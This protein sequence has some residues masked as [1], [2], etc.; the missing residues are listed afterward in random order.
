[1]ASEVRSG[2]RQQ[3]HSSSE[4]PSEPSADTGS[5]DERE[6]S[7]EEPGAYSQ[8]SKPDVGTPRIGQNIESTDD[9]DRD[10]SRNG[11][12]VFNPR[13]RQRKRQQGSATSTPDQTRID[14]ESANRTQRGGGSKGQNDGIPGR[15][16][17]TNNGALQRIQQNRP[18]SSNNSAGRG[19]TRNGIN[20]DGTPKK[21]RKGSNDA[22]Y[23]E[24]A[25]GHSGVFSERHGNGSNLSSALAQAYAQQNAGGARTHS[26]ASAVS[27]SSVHDDPASGINSS[28]NSMS[29]KKPA[30]PWATGSVASQMLRDREPRVSPA[31]AQKE[32][33]RF[34]DSG[35][36]DSGS[37]SL[38]SAG[39]RNR[40]VDAD[41]DV[42]EYLL[43][44]DQYN[45]GSLS[46]LRAHFENIRGNA[47]V[48]EAEINS[49]SQPIPKPSASSY[50]RAMR[51]N[52]S[53]P[54]GGLSIQES[55][56]IDNLTLSHGAANQSFAG[57][58]FMATSIPL[59]DHFKDIARGDAGSTGT[60]PHA[61]S[62]TR[63]PMIGSSGFLLN[64]H[65]FSAVDSNPLA[66]EAHD[67]DISGSSSLRP[68][69][70]G[71]LQSQHLDMSPAVYP[72][73]G[74]QSIPLANDLFG[75]SLR[76]SSLANEPRS[77]LSSF[78]GM[79][80]ELV[81]NSAQAAFLG[82]PNSA[83]GITPG[84][85]RLRSNSN[86]KSPSIGGLSSG[87]DINGYNGRLATVAG[88]TRVPAR[89]TSALLSGESRLAGYSLNGVGS[90]P[91][92][93]ALE[94]NS[95]IW[96]SHTGAGSARDI[97][98][99]YSLSNKA[100]GMQ[101]PG[102]SYGQQPGS[103]SNYYQQGTSPFA[104]AV[105]SLGDY[106]Q[107]QAQQHMA[108]SRMAFGLP[109][110]EGAIGQ[111]LHQNQSSAFGAAP[112][113]PRSYPYAGGLSGS[114][115]GIGSSMFAIEAGRGKNGSANGSSAASDNI[116][117]LF[118]LEQDVPAQ[119]RSNSNNSLAPNPP[120]ISMDGFS[121]KF[122]G[123]SLNRSEGSGGN[124]AQ[125][126]TSSRSIPSISA[127][128]RPAA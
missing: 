106:R 128:A 8:L 99:R 39:L 85:G 49:R 74:A 77:P 83:G 86:A 42:P 48:S 45:S 114:F 96:D 7:S 68:G 91:Y 105:G 34:A 124:L 80:G 36:S 103:L 65:A 81:D 115:G 28:D 112:G 38:R 5:R 56:M 87:L 121:H 22:S 97:D 69:Y 1:M 33:R 30:N 53:L 76:S 50:N 116:D 32:R 10:S 31:A 43:A 75:R 89:D 126:A 17:K 90:L 127:I 98:S 21:D 19:N 120:F 93:P 102:A 113:A 16:Q 71:H 123:L 60:S 13:S 61:Q 27:S 2:Q 82:S 9:S 88:A 122:S 107:Q 15:N 94:P 47:G 84:S 11:T 104:T 25:G 14:P 18:A 125:S 101:R 24:A 6:G 92:E 67:G 110:G 54:Y 51:G 35:V 95:G 44:G 79:N 55:L 118:E 59:L 70:H 41:G 109:S 62:F 57:S 111:R 46:P 72:V 58:P 119:S 100:P 3:S 37:A 23:S 40:P 117:E 20:P 29:N 52:N 73:G 66:Q 63:S 4:S 64:R 26:T 78:N 108:Q 12:G